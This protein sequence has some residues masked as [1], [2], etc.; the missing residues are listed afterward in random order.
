MNGEKRT[1]KYSFV[2]SNVCTSLLFRLPEGRRKLLLSVV[3]TSE[4]T[5]QISHLTIWN[6]R[7]QGSQLRYIV[8]CLNTHSKISE[9]YFHS[10]VLDGKE[11]NAII[12]FK[13]LVKKMHKGGP[14]RWVCMKVLDP[15]PS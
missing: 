7:K 15:K 12:Y 3:L 9:A 4:L 5:Q 10:D 13:C 1:W 2:F 14:E 8:S 6:C 11:D